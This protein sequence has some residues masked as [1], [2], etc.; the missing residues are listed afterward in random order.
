MI[1]LDGSIGGGQILRTA[2]SLSAITGK[3][4]NIKNIRGVRKEPGLK[5][6]HLA[7]VN[8]VK[9]LC[10]ARVKG[11]NIKSG[12]LTFTPGK[13]KSGNYKF[14]IPTAGSSLL[15]LQ[16]VLPICLQSKK[17]SKIE[18]MG[19]TDNPL[20]PGSIWFSRV[21]N[22]MLAKLGAEVKIEITRHG[23]FPKGRGKVK[24]TIN[25]VK[26][27]KEIM[28]NER[29]ALM[30]IDVHAVATKDLAKRKVTERMIEGFKKEFKTKEQ[31]NYKTGYIESASTGCFLHAHVRYE[32]MKVG[33]TLLG[34]MGKKSEDIGKELARKIKKLMEN[35]GVDKFLG[36]QLMIYMALKGKGNM[37]VVEITGHM[38]TNAEV[39]EKFLN[40][41][42]KCDE[43]NKVIVCG[44]VV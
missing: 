39:I 27:F 13:V 9:E 2:L 18:I 16:T 42:F 40:V 25:A 21:F 8:A 22:F 24:A 4:F 15:L 11:D 31:V 19:G 34:E 32:K 1:S 41:K 14:V 5:N 20:A 28:L 35:N 38:R 43:K 3:P 33:D 17:Q 6:Q 7:A 26:E 36:D 23:F 44:P 10:D 30:K 37:K 29:G 12:E